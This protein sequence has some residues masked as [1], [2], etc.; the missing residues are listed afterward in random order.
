MLVSIV[1]AIDEK[2][3]IGK[4]GKLPWNIPEDLKHFKEITLGHTIIMGRKTF[5]SI[6]RILP[7]RTSIVITRDENLKIEGAVIVHSL[8]EA[9]SFARGGLAKLGEVFII[10]GGQ[11]FKEAME[12]NLVDKIYL[13]LVEGDFGCDTF[14]PDYSDFKKIKSEEEFQSGEYKGKFLILEK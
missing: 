8:D 10:G 1:V 2:R 14:F 7:N 9:I 3:G 4:A 5:E 6:G 11:V 12:K 13:T